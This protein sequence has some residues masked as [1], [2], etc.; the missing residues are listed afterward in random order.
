MTSRARSENESAPSRRRAPPPLAPPLLAW[1]DEHRRPLPWRANLDP[2][3]IWLSEIMLQQTRIEV[4]RGYYDRFLA[5]FDTVEALASAPEAEVL[6]L[7]AGLG[8]YSRA[9]NLHA[10]ARVVVHQHGGVFPATVEGLRALPGIGRYTAGAIASIAFGVRAPVLDGNVSRVLARLHCIGGDVRAQKVA[11]RLWTIASDEVPAQRPGDFNQAL[12]E[13]GEVICTP[14]SPRCTHCPLRGSCRARKDDRV[15][16]FPAPRARPSRPEVT[17]LCGAIERDGLFLFVRRTSKGLLGGLWELPGTE[18]STSSSGES[19]LAAALRER[20]GLTI[21]VAQPLGTVRHIFTHRALS[22]SVFRCT[23]SSGRVELGDGYVEHRWLPLAE[24]PRQLA[25][26][27]VTRK[28]L[29][30]LAS[31]TGRGSGSPRGG[32]PRSRRTG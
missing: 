20:V 26:P 5:H 32:R 31:V 10:A 8:Y 7:W 3:R 30:L 1:Y 9:R 4:V 2:Y 24:A 19:T 14:R 28:A 15:T 22:L 11:A 27:S 6:R 13:L 18:M 21:D 23:R 25:L 17:A 16:D 29:A 12:M